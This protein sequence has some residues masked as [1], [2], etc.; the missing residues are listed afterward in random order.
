MSKIDIQIPEQ[1][2]E[3]LGRKIGEILTVELAN[4]TDAAGVTVWYERSVR[5]DRNEVPAVNVYF[6][7]V[8][9]DAN[10]PINQDGNNDYVIDIYAGANYTDDGRGDVLAN[11]K[12]K[13]LLGIIRYILESQEYITLDLPR[14]L[15]RRTAVKSMNI[16]DITS[17]EQ[18][19]NSIVMGRI[20]FEVQATEDVRLSSSLLLD[21]NTTKI[22]L[23]E[24][25]KGFQ[26]QLIE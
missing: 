14:P 17:N 6:T 16:V 19:T 25:E 8:E 5:F 11:S 10:T 7:Q 1:N 24:T 22:K 20:A 2:F 15:V 13:R 3:L 12:V 26:Y 9:Y 18:D 4:Q 23:D 21:Q